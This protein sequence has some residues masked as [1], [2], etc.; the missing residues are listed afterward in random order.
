MAHRTDT[1]PR[2]R[3]DLRITTHAGKRITTWKKKCI[4]RFATWNIKSFNNKD[5]ETLKELK[6]NKIDVCA[7]QE[8]K[9]KGKG[10]IQYDDYLV[11]Y[12]GVE[13]Q[14]RAKEGVAIAISRKY[15]ANIQDCSYVSPRILV[16]RMEAEDQTLN[17][18]SVYSPEDNKPKQ[19][20]ESFYDQLQNTIESLP[21]DQ[22]SIILGDFNAR[23]GNQIIPGIK[24]RFNENVL[25]DNGELM[26]DLCALNELRINNTFYDHKEQHK[27]T[28]GSTRGYRSTIDYIVTNR[29]I[30]PLQILD[31]RTLNSANVGSDHSLLLAKIK[32]KLKPQKKQEQATRE[33]KINIESLWDPSI[34][35]LYEKR[36]T[37]K[38]QVNPIK[39]EDNINTSWEKLKDNIKAAACEALGTRTKK[40]N[41][42]T[43]MNKTPWFRPEIKEKCREK[44]IAYLTYRTLRTQESYE[45]YKRIRNETTALVRQTKNLHWE[46]FSKR[47]ESDFYGLQ[48]QIWRFIRTQR[49]EIN[50]LVET[51]HIAKET[52]INYLSELFKSEEIEVEINTPEIVTNDNVQIETSDINIALRKM[53][54]RKSPGQDDI[55]NELLKYGGPCLIQQLT[56]LIQK[57]IYQHRIPDEWRTSTTILMFKRGDKKLPSNYRGINLLSTTLKLTTKVITNKINDLTSLADEQQG[58]RSGRSCTDA[59]FIIR[60]ITE[61]SIEYN[62]PA[63]MCFIDLEKAFDRVQLRDVVHLLYNRQIPYNLIKTIENIYEANLIQARINGDLTEPINVGCGIRQGDSLSPLLFNIIMDEII[64]NVRLLKGYSMG[65]QEITILCYAD[66]AVLVA[67]NEDDLQRLL[68]RFN[69]TAKSLNMTISTQ[70][71]K[72]MTTSK[73]PLRCKLEVE[74]RVIQQE[75]KFRYLGIEISGY[76]DVEAEVREL[77]TKATRIAG[78]LNDTIWRNKNIKVETKS[79]IYKAMVRPTMTYTAETRPDTT[80][81]KQLLETTEMRVLRRMTGKTLLDRERSESIRRTCNVESVNEWT[82]NRKKEWNEHISRMDDRRMVRIA[83]DKSPLGRRSP[84]RPRKR[85]SDNLAV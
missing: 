72:C 24:Q 40:V 51:N 15:Q 28:F 17:I 65:D 48:K 58:F 25:N 73:V 61:K 26:I 85:W 66:D 21:N 67:E 74:G 14:T 54:N 42:N 43:K 8:T 56:S 3:T 9:K 77:T 31:V 64:R 10:H 62:R 16:V 5:Q 55:P 45:A 36:L 79:R 38:I 11:I 81:T 82:L 7:L 12:S 32:L 47:M 78:C 13:K 68:H 71:T 23:I 4:M 22:Q 19:E 1:L 6:D 80:K 70:K 76:G 34:K 59:V 27:F 37:E 49:K 39:A 50:E 60:Q 84:G 57:I 18:V 44:K 41:N 30:H 33:S 53:K 52:W 20:R 69:C 83:R 75:M 35:Q 2:K 29:Y 46:I 63:Y